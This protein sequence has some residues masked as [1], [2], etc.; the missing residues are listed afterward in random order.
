[1][2]RPQ[3]SIHKANFARRSDGQWLKAMA[4]IK[5]R[6]RNSEKGLRHR[7]HSSKAVQ[8]PWCSC[9]ETRIP[10]ARDRRFAH[11]APEISTKASPWP[12]SSMALGSVSLR[13]TR[14]AALL[15]LPQV[16]QIIAG[17]GP[18]RSTISAK[19]AS[20]VSTIAL[21]WLA[22]AKCLCPSHGA[23]QRRERTERAGEALPQ[24][25]R[26]GRATDGR[27]PRSC[28]SQ[29]RVVELAASVL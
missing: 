28:R 4:R 6:I 12:I 1:M 7:E 11:Q 19:S 15:V 13:S 21:A 14:S 29:N 18:S 27:P 5:K 26:P 23:A 20:L 17:G 25:T 24:S 10:A 22:A 8:H 3:S 9:W 2:S 16:N